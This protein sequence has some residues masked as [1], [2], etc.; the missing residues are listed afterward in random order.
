[1]KRP[2]GGR[3][4]DDFSP[5]VPGEPGPVICWEAN[6]LTFNG[7][8]FFGSANTNNQSTAFTNGWATYGFNPPA[9]SV[10]A[11]TPLSTSAFDLTAGTSAPASVTYFGLPVVGYAAQTFNNDALTIGGVTYLSTFA[12]EFVHHKTTRIEASAPN[13]PG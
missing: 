8:N 10:H 2:R 7:G 4:F 9:G 3:I 13:N 11:M 5:Q 12:A 6:V 1:M